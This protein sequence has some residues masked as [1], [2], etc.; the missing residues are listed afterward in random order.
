LYK[1]DHCGE[2]PPYTRQCTTVV[3][4]LVIGYS[5]VN[6]NLS[7]HK[8][9]RTLEIP[10]SS[11]VADGSLFFPTILSTITS[12]V[13]SQVIA[14]YWDYNFCY[15]PRQW[16]WYNLYTIVPNGWEKDISAC[17]RE[18]GVFHEMRKVHDFQLVLCADVWNSAI[19]YAA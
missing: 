4:I 16:R 15:A 14:V 11:L 6:I 18:F 13:F 19:A 12:I 9:L 5:H 2:R 3:N 17:N 7:K 8:L 1:T 10:A